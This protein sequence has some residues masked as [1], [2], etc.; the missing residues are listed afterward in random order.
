MKILKDIK[1][2]FSPSLKDHY[3]LR[4]GD[5]DSELNKKVEV[6]IVNDDNFIIYLDDSYDI[7]WRYNDVFVEAAHCGEILSSVAILQA[8]SNFIENKKILRFIRFQIAEALARCFAG[9]SIES[10]KDILKEV[11]DQISARNYEMAWRW[12]FCSA[13]EWTCGILF[14]IFLCFLFSDQ[15]SSVVGGAIVEIIW[16]AGAGVLGALSSVRLRANRIV[17]DANAGKDIHELEGFS[18]VLAGLIAAILAAVIYKSEIFSG[19][20]KSTN[21]ELLFLIVIGFFAGLSERFIPS[22]VSAI[23]DKNSSS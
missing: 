18:R 5:F 6:L 9:Q 1:N 23:D 11:E 17:M 4:E 22:L 10:S 19:V 3:S 12:Y 15:L 14:V 16:V 2:L 7:Q 20:L 8:K 13:L 21:N